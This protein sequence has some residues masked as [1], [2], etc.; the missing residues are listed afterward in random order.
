MKHALPLFVRD[1]RKGKAIEEI[2]V[3]CDFE[4]VFGSLQGLSHDRSDPLQ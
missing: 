1:T 2:P 3:V 4:D